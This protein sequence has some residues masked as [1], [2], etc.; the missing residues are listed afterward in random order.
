MLM[1]RARY[2]LL[3]EAGSAVSVPVRNKY[4]V[5]HFPEP[6]E[7]R[8]GET[9]Y[10]TKPNAVIVSRPNEPRWFHFLR[11]T[12]FSFLHTTMAA[13]EL[14]EKYGIPMGQILYPQ[15]PEFLSACFRRLFVEYLSNER[16]AEEMQDAYIH[17]LLIKLSRN[18]HDPRVM[19]GGKL[20]KQMLNLRVDMLSQAEKKWNVADMAATLSLSPSRFHVVYKAMFGIPPTKDLIQARVDRAKVLLLEEQHET[21]CDI[22]EKLG[23]KNP[24]DFSRQFKQITGTSPGSY[25]K[26]NQ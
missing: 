9:L 26:K 4:S 18:L 23:Y 15:N 3:W 24:Y 14:F 13:G 21:L 25:R 10:V 16:N 8:I 1:V 6:V 2:N 19:P 17:E 22:A 7:I 20:Q 11:D 12:R 5:F